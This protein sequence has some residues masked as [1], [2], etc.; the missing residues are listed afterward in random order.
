MSVV[1]SEDDNT[2]LNAFSTVPMAVMEVSDEAVR[3]VRTNQSYRDFLKRYFWP[4]LSYAPT[5]PGAAPLAAESFF[6]GYAQECCE[7]KGS[8]VYFDGTLPDGSTASC[9]MRHVRTNPV[10]GTAAIVVA[11]ISIS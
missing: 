2:L 5:A 6:R 3:F 1:V 9:L 10:T 7:G 4:S 8:R 11:V